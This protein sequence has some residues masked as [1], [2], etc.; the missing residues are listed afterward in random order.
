[1]STVIT[2]INASDQ[3]TNSRTDI[4]NNFAS[5]NTNK[6]E[7]SV[8]D[9]DSTLSANSDAKIPSQ[10]AVKAYVDAGGNVNASTTVKGIVEEATQGEV[11][12]GTATGGTGARL[13][14]NPSATQFA[15]IA[16]NTASKV[17]AAGALAATYIKTYFNVQLNFILWAGAVVNDTTTTFG[18]WVRSDGTDVIVQAG[19]ANIFFTSTGA[20]SISCPLWFRPN[21]TDYLL[22]TSPNNVVMDVWIKFT[23]GTGDS[24]SGFA[25]N[26]AALTS[27]YTST[28]YNKVGFSQ[29]AG[30]TLYATCAKAGIAVTNTSVSS[31]IT[32]TNWN[33]YRIELDPSNNALFYI[34]GVLK[35]TTATNIPTDG[36]SID[37]GFGRSDTA[38]FFVTAPNLAVQ[39]AGL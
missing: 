37:P 32:L 6:I 2:T 13:F 22:W 25:D 27:V 28:V 12:A 3:I 19:G 36:N 21:S 14:V 23:S 29:N 38:I 11:D 34:N 18:N 17:Y 8:I 24:F 9:T 35:A 10:K 15:A 30:G 26:I 31:G 7:T 1:M 4:N 5:L 39:L 33:N 16:A 20:A